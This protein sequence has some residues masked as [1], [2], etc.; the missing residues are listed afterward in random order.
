MSGRAKDRLNVSLCTVHI[1]LKYGV[2]LLAPEH[3]QTAIT[4]P[5][6][7][8]NMPRVKWCKTLERSHSAGQL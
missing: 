1:T 7:H 6:P 5:T 4:S 8:Q 3:N 2:L